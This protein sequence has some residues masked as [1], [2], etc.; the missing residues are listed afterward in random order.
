MA[1]NATD[2]SNREAEM[3]AGSAW[4]TSPQDTAQAGP[5]S[6]SRS[7][8]PPVHDPNADDNNNA[9][10]GHSTGAG[11]DGGG[12]AGSGADQASAGS[13]G[14]SEASG[15]GDGAGAPGTESSGLLSG[16]SL[17]GLSL[18]GLNLGGT[19]GLLQPVLDTIGSLDGS[20]GNTAGTGG[21]VQGLTGDTTGI[22]GLSPESGLLNDVVSLPGSLLDGGN[23]DGGLSHIGTDLTNTAGAADGLLNGVLGD[24][25]GSGTLSGLVNG[26]TGET[27]G[28]GSVSGLVNG[29][30]SGLLGNPLATVDGGNNAND[31]GLLGAT[32]AHLTGSSSGNAVDVDAG[33]QTDN[34]LGLDVLA[35]PNSDSGHTVG[36]GALDVGSGG[37]QIADIGALTGA[38]ALNTSALSG[39]G[40][41]LGLNGLGLQDI[42]GTHTGDLLTVNGGNNANDGGVIGGIVGGSNGASG[43]QLVNADVGPNQ[44]DNNIDVLSS[45]TADN[46]T[47]AANAVDVGPNGPHLADLGVLTSP[48]TISIPTLNGTG[49][50]GLS[51]LTG[52]LLGDTADS[53]TV[54]ASPTV[55]APTD[56]GATEILPGSITG[57]HGIV[58]VNNHHIV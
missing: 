25:D 23:L 42:A 18:G 12:P 1:M 16:T 43:G 7:E 56:L 55:T 36:V 38:N 45:S 19:D 24:T 27:G 49:T 6:T 47:V 21:I 53:N 48:G 11:S 52:H 14:G 13:G 5:N 39:L 51:G 4:T 33:P 3:T 15:G 37:P 31:G 58:D 2:A 57:D 22:L 28:S 29:L 20:L 34:G 50:D 54:T 30:D 8:P 35:S 44:N 9:E 10:N 40:N 26:I 32:I 41:S 46:H 17:G